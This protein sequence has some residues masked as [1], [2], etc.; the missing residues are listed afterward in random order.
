M[1]FSFSKIALQIF[2]LEQ[3]KPKILPKLAILIRPF[4]LKPPEHSIQQLMPGPMCQ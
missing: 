3:V 2:K 4:H 1:F